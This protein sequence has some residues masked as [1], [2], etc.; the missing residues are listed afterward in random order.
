[1]NKQTEKFIGRLKSDKKLLFII[2]LGISGMLL[3]LLSGNTDGKKEEKNE[4]EDYSVEQISESV[5]KKLTALIKSVSGVG[6]VRVMVSIDCLEEKTVAVNTE[7]EESDNK[8]DFKDEYVIIE[9]TQGTDGLVL[10]ITTPK[11]R[12]VGIT[13]QGAQ[14][15]TVRQEIIKLVSATLGIPVNRIW[16]SEMKE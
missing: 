7:R 9:K 10:K 2:V 12:G 14:S 1:M 6:N 5:E 3:L 4:G 16:V 15:V 13:C 11:I 8:T